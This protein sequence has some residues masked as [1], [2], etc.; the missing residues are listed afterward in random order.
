MPMENESKKRF[1]RCD[2][3]FWKKFDET[4]KLDPMYKNKS[5]CIRGLMRDYINATYSKN[6]TSK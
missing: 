4:V 6:E 1:F 3:V 2:D 5:D